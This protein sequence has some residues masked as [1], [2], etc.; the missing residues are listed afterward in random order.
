MEPANSTIG[1]TTGMG[2]IQKSTQMRD[3]A[4][5]SLGMNGALYELKLRSSSYCYSEDG[6]KVPCDGSK[7]TIP[8]FWYA[9]LALIPLPCGKPQS[10]YK[11]GDF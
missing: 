6:L 2:Q 1:M 4:L 7:L 11:K 9:R 5:L 10:V 3:F 8:L